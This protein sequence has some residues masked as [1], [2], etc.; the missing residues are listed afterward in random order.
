M[1]HRPSKLILSQKIPGSLGR[2]ERL[3]AEHAHRLGI[4]V[5]TASEK[6]MERGRLELNDDVLVA[7]TAP[8]VLHALRH[9]NVPAPEHT[10]Y[11]DVLSPWLYR[12]VWRQ[13]RLREVIEHLDGGGRRLFI[14]PARGWKRFTGFVAEFGTDY[15]LNGVSKNAPV[16][17]SEPLE[18]VSEWRAYVVDGR[19]LAIK[20]ADYGGDRCIEPDGAEIR[21]A[22]A[23]LVQAKLAPA[24]FVIDFGVTPSGA[25]ALIE[26]NDGFSFGAY[27]SVDAQVYWS[28]TVARWFELIREARKR[29]SAAD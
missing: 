13:E 16:W 6:M 1:S 29:R 7:G 10:P 22:V 21:E 15:R 14:K 18:F 11:P 5:E 4:R 24:G 17:V 9:L 23:R 26:M 8:F 28:V 20:F 19:V 12:R 3:L 25:T 2:E 27:D